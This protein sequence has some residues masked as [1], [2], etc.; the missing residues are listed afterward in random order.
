MKKAAAMVA[1]GLGPVRPSVV[2]FMMANTGCILGIAPDQF[3]EGL[4]E[5]RID[6]LGMAEQDEGEESNGEPGKHGFHDS[7][8]TGTA[9]RGGTTQRWSRASVRFSSA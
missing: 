3:V 4:F 9:T 7:L 8:S 5:E 6:R 2:V 1:S